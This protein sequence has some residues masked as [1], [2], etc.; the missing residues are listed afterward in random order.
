M[1]KRK[2][3]LLSAALSLAL[4]F[5]VAI[6]CFDIIGI[7]AGPA[8]EVEAVDSGGSSSS[9]SSSSTSSSTSTAKKSKKKTAKKKLK[10]SGK[11]V[12]IEYDAAQKGNT[13]LGRDSIMTVKNAGGKKTYTIV[14]VSKKKAKKF[15]K[16]SKKGK[17]TVKKGLAPGTYTITIKVKTSGNSKC[18]AGNKKVKV[19]VVV[20]EPVV[21][22]TPAPTET[23][24]TTDPGTGAES[25]N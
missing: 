4:M 3:K 13:V 24:Q 11:T 17:L 8:Y 12:S 5:T 2:S 21:V 9:S 22:P 23:S 19:K 16:I 20:N 14:K 7:L 1:G 10:V 6:G 25:S 18:R 15:F